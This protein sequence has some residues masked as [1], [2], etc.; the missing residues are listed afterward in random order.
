MS[1]EIIYDGKIMESRL[2]VLKNLAAVVVDSEIYEVIRNAELELSRKQQLMEFIKNNDIGSHVYFDIKLKSGFYPFIAV[3]NYGYAIP[4]GTNSQAFLEEVEVLRVFQFDDPS[5]MLGLKQPLF[6]RPI[7][8]YE[9]K[10][11]SLQEKAS[12][13][14]NVGYRPTLDFDAFVASD[15]WKE[16]RTRRDILAE[17]RETEPYMVYRVQDVFSLLKLYPTEPVGSNPIS[18]E[19]QKMIIQAWSD[20]LYRE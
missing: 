4:K 17:K 2:S 14:D 9:S 13:W 15:L 16:L 18:A 19:Y 11:L 12:L 10:L 8:N 6:L 20:Y 3:G 5:D 1:T 7:K